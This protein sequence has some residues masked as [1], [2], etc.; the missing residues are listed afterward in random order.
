[1]QSGLSAFTLGDTFVVVG[2]IITALVTLALYWKRQRDAADRLRRAVVAELVEVGDT[3]YADIQV[4]DPRVPP[5]ELPD[6]SP[7]V[8]TVFENNAGELGRLSTTE[9]ERITTYYTTAVHVH[10]KLTRLC[11]AD[12]VTSEQVRYLHRDLVEL[13]NRRNE[14]LDAI[15]AQFSPWWYPADERLPVKPQ[16]REMLE[17]DV[18][19]LSDLSD[20]RTDSGPAT[21]GPRGPAS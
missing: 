1:M 4:L 19:S 8:T 18:L 10:R 20:A 11:E 6:D 12:E 14:A 3:V 16:F 2:A 7:I 5:A 17:A 13:N 9:T 15:G 21:D